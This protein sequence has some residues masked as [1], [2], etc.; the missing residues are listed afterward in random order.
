M[1]ISYNEIISNIRQGKYK[2]IGEGSSRKVFD[3]NNG[4]VVKIAKN[5][6]GIEQN[7]VE[8]IISNY[9]RSH[10]FAKV[11]QASSNYNF[12]IMRKA[13]KINSIMDVCNYFNVSNKFKFF[14]LPQIRELKNKYDLILNDLTRESSWGII[15]GQVVIINYGYTYEI[16]KKYY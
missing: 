13:R 3:L 11:V 2:Y 4:Y 16:K 14:S 1:S 7:K 9:D 8:Y 12:I 5:M 10:L 6:A 15:N